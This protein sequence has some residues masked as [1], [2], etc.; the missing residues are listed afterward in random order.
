MGTR[1][2]TGALAVV[3]LSP[4]AQA[5]EVGFDGK[6]GTKSWFQTCSGGRTN[7]D[8]NGLPGINDDVTIAA[9]VG[10]V[11]LGSG[12]GALRVDLRSLTAPGGLRLGSMDLS[13]QKSSEVTGLQW[14]NAAITTGESLAT[15]LTLAGTSAWRTNGALRGSLLN[16]PL[17]GQFVNTGDLVI[18]ARPGLL[19]RA[20]LRN[21]G[22][23]NQL[24]YLLL[25]PDAAI[26]NANTWILGENNSDILR[27]QSTDPPDARFLNQSTLRNKAGSSTIG[28]SFE[29]T[30]GS[31]VEVT[32]GKLTFNGGASYSGPIAASKD[33]RLVAQAPEGGAQTFRGEVSVTGEGVLELQGGTDRKHVVEGT[34]INSLKS[35]SDPF[36][37]S[38][39]GGLLLNN[40]GLEIA[41]TGSVVNVGIM[42]WGDQGI[43]AG[44]VRGAGAFQNSTQGTLHVGSA[45]GT[46]G[47]AT[48][49]AR[50]ENFGRVEQYRTLALDADLLPDLVVIQNYADW[51]LLDG[52]SIERQG[53]T[54]GTRIRNLGKFVAYSRD[55]TVAVP[56]DMVG[57]GTLVAP[58]GA[59]VSLLGGGLWSSHTPL[60]VGGVVQLKG[61][62]STDPQ[63]YV[64]EGDSRFEQ[65]PDL[66]VEDTSPPQVF[67]ATSGIL[68]VAGTLVNQIGNDRFLLGFAGAL[69]LT[70][71]KIEGPGVLTND[72]R[73]DVQGGTL[74]TNAARL[75][76]VNKPGSLIHEW[77]S[78]DGDVNLDGRIENDGSLLIGDSARLAFHG[79]STIENSGT[80]SFTGDNRLQPVAPGDGQVVNRAGARL[81]VYDGSTRLEV[82]L[83]NQGTVGVETGTLD[84][85]GPVAQVS[86]GV[87]TGGTW[88]V[89]RG[90]ARLYIRQEEI[91]TIGAGATVYLGS[92]T[93]GTA[94]NK[95][96]H[97]E[98]TLTVPGTIQRDSFST[99]PTGKVE[100]PKPAAGPQ[101]RIEV[102]SSSAELA[103]VLSV[104]AETVIHLDLNGGQFLNEGTLVPGGSG[105]TGSFGV[106]GDFVQTSTGVLQID[107]GTLE[108]DQLVVTGAAILGGMLQ[109]SLLDGFLP[110]PQHSFTAVLA[111]SLTGTFGNAVDTLLLPE[112]SFQVT[113][114]DGAVVLTGFEPAA[115]VPLPATLPLFAS[116]LLGFA[117]LGATRRRAL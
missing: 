117:A 12:G 51:F 26:T 103:S 44:T 85:A 101:Q 33:A 84:I 94:F 95:A 90:A 20:V 106:D 9:G 113:Y 50:L 70:G 53:A 65:L 102:A 16:A 49:G 108:Y 54:S 32:A 24:G 11:V 1:W 59:E 35:A 57:E 13:L 40:V 75:R 37:V 88:T 8:N 36:P 64:I 107:I 41:S 69:S 82:P 56:F 60:Q 67:I 63:S 83:D 18:E 3:A 55:S 28:V 23:V 15:G 109:V 22:T 73:M 110:D 48:L 52:A 99:G 4:A 25:H 81:T 6:C 5:A 10:P 34:L 39:A 19:Q 17:L 96:K 98:G 93:A 105:A 115:A 71:G 86:N 89:E 100:T 46:V 116:S 29:G 111:A 87:L 30:A 68:R 104:P 42:R 77:L 66:P 43:G 47:T 79:D 76:L 58:V 62:S 74:G 72:G 38:A 31:L 92:D 112:G 114:A 91:T 78:I 80:M 7:W 27:F 2:L 45:L 14:E 97:I 61:P 21:E